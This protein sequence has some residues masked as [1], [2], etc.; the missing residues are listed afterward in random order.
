MTLDTPTRLATGRL[1]TTALVTGGIAALLTTTLAFISLALAVVT[2][3]VGVLALRR[4][5]DRTLAAVGLAMA[6]VSTYV[7]VLEILILGG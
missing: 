4:G 7:I 6:G 3:F 2:A 5:Q 1:A